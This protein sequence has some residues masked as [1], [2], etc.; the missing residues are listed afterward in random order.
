MKQI[1]LTKDKPYF[2]ANLHCHSTVSDGKKTPQELKEM[3][4]AHGYS[5]IAYTDHDVLLDHSDLNDDRFLALNSFEMEISEEVAQRN[6]SRRTCHLCYIALK[7]DNLTQVCYHRTKYLFANA[8]N[9]RSQ[10][11]F[12]ESK[13][14]FVREYTPECINEMIAEGRRNGFFVTYNHPAWSQENAL[15]YCSYRGMNAMEICNYSSVVCGFPD[16]HENAYDDILRGGQKCYCV[17]TDDNHN[18][19]EDSYGGFTVIN[20]DK[21]EYTMVTD[22]LVNGDFYASEGPEIYDLWYEDGKMGITCSD[23]A[24]I[25][26][27]CGK[28]R[29]KAFF[30]KEGDVLTSAVFE[31]PDD[32]VYARITVTDRTGKHANTNAYYIED[33]LK[34]A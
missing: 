8:V 1:L 34:K 9:Y 7:P 13:P 17:S 14:D 5:V 6:P 3:Y 29:A 2:K 18:Y 11:Q 22:A 33:L 26:L 20:A 25:R 31:V 15:E 24:S 4:M 28:R 16:Y 12:D 23:A 32:S 27:L 30:A 21:L 10:I 19:G